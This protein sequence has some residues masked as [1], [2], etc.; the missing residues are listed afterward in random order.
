MYSLNRILNRK[1]RGVAL[2]ELGISL[3]FLVPLLLL[4]IELSHA[5]YEDQTLVKQVRAGARYL[6]TQPVA[7]VGASLQPY[8]VKASCL[9]R[10]STLDCFDPNAKPVLQNLQSS[11][12]RISDSQV[13]DPT[14]KLFAQPTDFGQTDS[15]TINLVKV[16]VE[17]YAHQ[18]FK[19][20]PSIN[21][22]PIVTVMRQ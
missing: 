19:G 4:T 11:M 5:F 8:W 9:V 13:N 3:L 12:I 17:G 18:F 2:V 20:M 14:E 22:P 6:T 21:F 7:I 16:S 1:N 10:L 15:T